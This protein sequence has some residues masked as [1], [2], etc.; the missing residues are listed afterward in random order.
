MKTEDNRTMEW[1]SVKERLPEE[2]MNVLVCFGTHKYDVE[3][4]WFDKGQWYDD[5]EYQ[6]INLNNVTHWMPL[7][8][9]PVA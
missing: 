8:E 3:I 9:I 5:T 1:I 2:R 4:G 7:P 6:N